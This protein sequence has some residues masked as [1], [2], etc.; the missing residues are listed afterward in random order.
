MTRVNGGDLRSTN[1]QAKKLKV[2]HTN[3]STKIDADPHDPQTDINR[4]RLLDERGRQ[5]WHY[6]QTDKEVEAWPQSI[7][8]RH[9]LGL[10]VVLLPFFESM[11]TH[12][13][14]TP[15]TRIF[16]SNPSRIHL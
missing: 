12:P 3:G 11:A 8:D 4:W 1:D 9:H 6:L 2:V 10:P 16:L 7:V 15:R 13:E 5:T 14:L